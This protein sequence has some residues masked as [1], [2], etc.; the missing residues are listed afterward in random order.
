[1]SDARP[2]AGGCLCGAVRYTVTGPLRPV[3]DCHC[4][5]CR[6]FTGHHMAATDAAVADRAVDDPT[7][8]LAWYPVPGAA[9]AFCRTCGS[10]LFWRADASPDR[11]SICAGTLEQP[12]GLRTV[13]AWWVS[14]AGDYFTRPDLPE[15]LTE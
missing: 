10:S 11:M 12:T 5:R 7:D 8:R 1:M 14:Q 9:Y 15:R 2:S 4:E 6:R 3:L 13:E